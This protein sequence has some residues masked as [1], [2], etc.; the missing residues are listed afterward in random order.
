[1]RA[2]VTQVV[3]LIFREEKMSIGYQRV[4]SHRPT[5]THACRSLHPYLRVVEIARE[6]AASPSFEVHVDPLAFVEAL[7]IH[8]F[9]IFE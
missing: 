8:T 6:G 9:L 3:D 1:M 2:K 4:W 5:N 7:Q